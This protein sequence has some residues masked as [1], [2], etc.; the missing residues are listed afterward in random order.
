MDEKKKEEKLNKHI[1]GNLLR[2]HSLKTKR[3]RIVKNIREIQE[4][5]GR[6]LIVYITNSSIPLAMINRED[7]FGF[8]D[9]LSAIDHN[10]NGDLLINSPGGEPNAADKILMM[11]KEHFSESF[12]TII[13]DY[14]KSAATLITLGSDKI[15]MGYT[16]ELGPIDPQLRFEHKDRSVPAQAYLSGLKYIKERI[17]KDKDPDP[18]GMYI[19]LLDKFD[20]ELIIICENS[21]DHSK[22]L[23]KKYLKSGMLKSDPSMADEVAELLCEGKKY[24]SHGKV[25]NFKEAKE[26]LKLNVQ[27]IEKESDLWKKVWECYCRIKMHLE[28]TNSLNLFACE[29]IAL[30][31][32]LSRVEIKKER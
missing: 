12:Y 23:A 16:S 19:P 7:V 1:F 21:I 15:L 5:T 25:I 31:Q 18:L 24:K 27:L 30:S 3:E 26:T 29:S 6:K 14:A 11:C 28:E 10:N 17:K 8:E 4:I 20:P 22:Q 9:I 13:P 32:N 2:E